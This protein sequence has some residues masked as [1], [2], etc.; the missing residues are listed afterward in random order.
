MKEKLIE[1]ARELIDQ[2]VE[3]L[4]T[5]QSTL[6]VK[7]D[8]TLISVVPSG[9]VAPSNAVPPWVYAGQI[10]VRS[11]RVYVVPF[12][13]N[14]N[15]SPSG[16]AEA[17]IGGTSLFSATRPSFTRRAAGAAIFIEKTWELYIDS[18]VVYADYISSQLVEQPIDD[19]YPRELGAV[20][21]E[22]TEF[23]TLVTVASCKSYTLLGVY[24]TAGRVF[25]GFGYS[26]TSS[27]RVTSFTDPDDGGAGPHILPTSF[28]AP[29]TKAW[30]FPP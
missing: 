5:S 23:P 22:P 7:R 13:I 12:V 14:T 30:T 25:P 20:D 6:R 24:T 28:V 2:R 4:M 16:T 29:Y 10:Q 18:G 9:R 27:L 8:E 11:D 21:F 19:P 15:Y 1:K 17:N 3:E 26:D